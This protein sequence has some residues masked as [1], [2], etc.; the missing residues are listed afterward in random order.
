M[1]ATGL[2]R[3]VYTALTQLKVAL[4]SQPFALSSRR[5]HAWTPER[6]DRLAKPAL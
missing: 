4:G 2:P 1:G 6:R 3:V 5:A